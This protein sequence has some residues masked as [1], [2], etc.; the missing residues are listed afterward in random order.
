[1]QHHIGRQK[2]DRVLAILGRNPPHVTAD[3][4]EVL[5]Q[6]AGPKAAHEFHQMLEK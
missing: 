2:M 6:V 3:F 4:L 5:G 1:M